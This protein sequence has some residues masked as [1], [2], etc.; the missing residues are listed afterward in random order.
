M[1]GN[2]GLLSWV[3]QVPGRAD[4]CLWHIEGGV[5]EVEGIE[6]YEAV[7]G[8]VSSVD[9]FVPGE[10]GRGHVPVEGV[11]EGCV[12][13]RRRGRT[14]CGGEGGLGA[15]EGAGSLDKVGFRFGDQPV[16]EGLWDVGVFLIR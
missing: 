2:S 12:G 7:G 15:R 1:F 16:G 11:R 8:F 10:V 9:T 4:I 13:V 6:F 3:D 14:K 5:E